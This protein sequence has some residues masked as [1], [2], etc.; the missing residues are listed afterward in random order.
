MSATPTWLSACLFG[1]ATLVAPWFILQPGMGVG[2]FA[3]FASNPYLTG[4]INIS[5]HLIFGAALC[6]CCISVTTVW[7]LASQL[8]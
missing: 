1:M 4:G 8:A 3:G 7:G 6:F 2:V 5:T